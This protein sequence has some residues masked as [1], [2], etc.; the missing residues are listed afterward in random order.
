VLY[1]RPLS[2]YFIY[3]KLQTLCVT[4]TTLYIAIIIL[5][6][7]NIVKF[8][9]FTEHCLP[10][11]TGAAVDKVAAPRRPR[12]EIIRRLGLGPRHAALSPGP[13]SSLQCRY[14]FRRR[15]RRKMGI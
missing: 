10:A 6:I 12:F 5:K 9:T 2:I 14:M 13:L 15:G 8:Y 3:H 7:Q 4:H 11:A 1:F